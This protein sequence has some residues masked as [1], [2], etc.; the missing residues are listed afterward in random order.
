MERTLSP[1]A[2]PALLLYLIVA[3]LWTWALWIPPLL[4]AIR[5][6]LVLPSPDN[7]A[8]LVA[9]GFAGRRHV[10]LAIIFSL[11][12]YGPLIGACLAT[13][14]E[15]DPRGVR[16][17]LANT[18]QA[19]FTP[20]WYLIALVIAAALSFIPSFF[21]WFT[22][23]L[24]QLLLEFETVALLFIPL[25]VLQLLTSGLG[26]EPGWRGYVLPRL[27]QRFSPHRS[28]WLLGLIWAAWHYPLTG[29]YVW[30]GVPDDT[31]AIGAVIAVIIGLLSQTLGVVGITYIYVW[32]FNRTLS[33]FLMMVFHALSNTFPLLVP[34]VQGGWVLFVGIFPWIIVFVLQRMVG[35]EQFPGNPVPHLRPVTVLAQEEVE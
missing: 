23:S 29:I 12:V 3:N 15:R 35:K 10:T 8:R 19:R 21:A 18:F 20:R 30:H 27:Q 22:G 2:R 34:S 17:L 31:P 6:R 11:A 24:N 16:A 5:Q 14:V 9:E 1:K 32:L 25:L 28:V 7:Y 33:L 4:I 13:A 26:E